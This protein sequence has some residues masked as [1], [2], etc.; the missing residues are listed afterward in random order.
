MKTFHRFLR[1]SFLDWIGNRPFIFCP[2]VQRTNTKELEKRE[3][4]FDI[5]LKWRSWG[6]V[7]GLLISRM[8]DIC[9]CEGPPKLPREAAACNRHLSRTIFDVMSLVCILVQPKT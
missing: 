6:E 3:K 7:S 8:E 4:F 1:A 9:T 5:I 2:V